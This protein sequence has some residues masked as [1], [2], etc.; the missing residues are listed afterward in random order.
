MTNTRRRRDRPVL[1]TN[2]RRTSLRR[3][4]RG[5]GWQLAPETESDFGRSVVSGAISGAAAWSAYALLEFVFA[6]VLFRLTRP[7]AVF[8]AWH[9]QFTAMLLLGYLTVGIGCGAAAGAAAWMSRRSVHLNIESAATFTLVL[10]FGLHLLFWRK[11]NPSRFWLLA[12][13]GVFGA[14]LLIPR[15]GGRAGWLTNCWIVSGLLLGFGQE[16]GLKGM[17]VASQLGAPLGKAT[18]I[19]AALL[20]GGVAAAVFLGRRFRLPAAPLRY[21]A[22]GGAALLMLASYALGRPASS[23]AEAGSPALAGTNRPNI[24]L[25]VMDTVQAAHLAVYGY[26]RD[27]TPNLRDLA[28][29]SMVYREA[30]SASDIT[31][32][33]H[34]SLF[35]GMRSE[36]HT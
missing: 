34:A 33:S 18:I 8:T 3:H 5:V 22:I 12:A 17:G 16:L 15:W 14:L 24:L 4:N 27:T 30:M 7:Y 29:D 31:P 21:G 23:N 20:L 13:A 11:A 28:R 32:T 1:H 26:D 25:V 2:T 19:L 36:E 6:S 10:A 9:W 35:T